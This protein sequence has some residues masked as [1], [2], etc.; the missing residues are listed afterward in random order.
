MLA[1]LPSQ[2]LLIL[3]PLIDETV[4]CIERAQYHLLHQLECCE[5]GP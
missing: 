5:Q 4:V 2:A 3:E 1:E